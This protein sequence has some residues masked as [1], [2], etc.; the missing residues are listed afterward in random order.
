MPDDM[1]ILNSPDAKRA[2]EIT[3]PPTTALP[4]GLPLEVLEVIQA[5]SA[6]IMER[7][8]RLWLEKRG[9][10]IAYH[11]MIASGNS[12]YLTVRQHVYRP[13]RYGN[14]QPCGPDADSYLQAQI[15]AILAIGPDKERTDGAASAT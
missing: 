5:S 13:T 4:P 14:H 3:G 15:A 2:F 10:Y 9:V 12:T 1:A 8:W 6:A 11:N 7:H